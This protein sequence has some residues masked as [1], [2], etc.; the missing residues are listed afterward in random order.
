MPGE[1]IH[2]TATNR[3]LAAN[4][5]LFHPFVACI[6]ELFASFEQDH[7][8]ALRKGYYR[9]G[10]CQIRGNALLPLRTVNDKWA[11]RFFLREQAE[12]LQSLGGSL[13]IGQQFVADG[14]IQFRQKSSFWKPCDDF[15]CEV[16]LGAHV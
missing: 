10:K 8:V 11:H 16:F 9:I 12:D 13:R 2:D 1:D 5:H 4:Y 14:S 3:E 15:G 6:D 7:R